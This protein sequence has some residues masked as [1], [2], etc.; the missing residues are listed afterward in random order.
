MESFIIGAG[1]A[2]IIGAFYYLFQKPSKK[3]HLYIQNVIL[4]IFAVILFVVFIFGL[5]EIAEAPILILPLFVVAVPGMIF[6]II[7]LYK[8]YQQLKNDNFEE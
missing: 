3:I 8:N 4:A 5:T 2:L 7:K 6:I 1:T